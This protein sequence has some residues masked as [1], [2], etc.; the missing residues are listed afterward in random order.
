LRVE[1]EEI[2]AE[3]P[4]VSDRSRTLCSGGTTTR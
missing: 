2:K 4:V 1:G 3:P